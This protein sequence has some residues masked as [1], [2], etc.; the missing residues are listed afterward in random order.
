MFVI[1]LKCKLE[2]SGKINLLEHSLP[3]SFV[4][5]KTIFVLR[6]IF[7]QLSMHS[8]SLRHK[9]ERG[10]VVNHE[11]KGKPLRKITCKKSSFLYSVCYALKRPCPKVT[12][13]SDP[14]SP[15]NNPPESL[16]TPVC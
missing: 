3:Q 15:G 8:L 16:R 9:W 7:L 11:T 14:L 1:V 4:L 10:T 5:C 12:F 6:V 13:D 2:W